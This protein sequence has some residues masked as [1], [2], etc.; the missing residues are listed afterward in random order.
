MIAGKHPGFLELKGRIHQVRPPSR[1]P[2]LSSN[3]SAAVLGGIGR[4]LLLTRVMI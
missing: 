3:S 4:D 2:V 1:E